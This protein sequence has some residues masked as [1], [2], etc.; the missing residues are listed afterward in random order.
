MSDADCGYCDFN[1]R[2]ERGEIERNY[3]LSYSPEY[4]R[5]YHSRRWM[6]Y[7]R[8]DWRSRLSRSTGRSESSL[9]EPGGILSSRRY[10]YR[11]AEPSDHH[12]RR[13]DSSSPI[14]SSADTSRLYFRGRRDQAA[15]VGERFDLNLSDRESDFERE[16]MVHRRYLCPG[17]R[18]SMRWTGARNC[19]E[20]SDSD[21]RSNWDLNREALDSPERNSRLARSLSGSRDWRL[22]D[23]DY[24]P[25]RRSL[26]ASAPYSYITE[27]GLSD[28][29][30]REGWRRGRSR[31]RRWD[32]H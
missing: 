6:N 2:L 11:A 20:G 29:E 13:R 1:D 5:H 22:Y 9:L 25:T 15:D 10:P 19:R 26:S 14:S 17:P 3:E 30:A 31:T 4:A 8:D 16:H 24:N 18:R 7:N 21:D 27:R 28:E 23:K 12:W 32:R